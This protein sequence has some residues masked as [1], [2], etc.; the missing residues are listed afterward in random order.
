MIP[1]RRRKRGTQ[2]Q[3]IRSR[4]GLSSKIHIVVDVLGNPLRF[5]LTAGQVH[6][7]TQA[8]A[9]VEGLTGAYLLADQG[10]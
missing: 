9:L 6:D 3:A 1:R 7:S 10:L 2:N 5:V 4:G 8:R